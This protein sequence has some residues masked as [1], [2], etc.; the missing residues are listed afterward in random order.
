MTC[1][2]RVAALLACV[3][4]AL[5]PASVAEDLLGP[6]RFSH[7]PSKTENSALSMECEGS[8]PYSAITC[9]FTQVMISPPSADEIKSSDAAAKDLEGAPWEELRKLRKDACDNV[10][11]AKSRINPPGL[12]A[13]KVALRNS[14]VGAMARACECR[15]APCVRSVWISLLRRRSCR[16]WANT[17]T[18]EFRRVPGEQKWISKAE[19][20]GLCNVVTVIVIEL[21]PTDTKLGMKWTYSQTRVAVDTS[22]PLCKGFELNAPLANA[23]DEPSATMLTCDDFTF[24]F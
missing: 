24:G 22:S 7:L 21:D 1:K 15:D 10:L 19:P 4:L 12:T 5:V 9:H 20:E 23:W 14:F 3:A 2:R 13:G 11:S 16:V 8:A 18:V 6:P 17:F